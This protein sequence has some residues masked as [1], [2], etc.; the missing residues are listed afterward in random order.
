[1]QESWAMVRKTLHAHFSLADEEMLYCG[2]ALGWPD[3][4]APVNRLRS[5][6]VAV[7]EFTTFKGF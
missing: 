4:D 7:D 3:A 6:R 1:M 2:M 5:D